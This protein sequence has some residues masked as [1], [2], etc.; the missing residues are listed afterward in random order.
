MLYAKDYFAWKATNE[1]IANPD[2][3]IRDILD[4]NFFEN[5]VKVIEDLMLKL[6]ESGY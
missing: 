6:A 5:N 4:E 2:I 1:A 3:I